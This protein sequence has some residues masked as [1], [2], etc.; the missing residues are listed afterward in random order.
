MISSIA[1]LVALT[2]PPAHTPDK[3]NQDA[4]LTAPV[5]P[6]FPESAR[7]AGLGKST[8]LVKVYLSAKGTIASLGVM[9]SSGNLDLDQAALRAAAQSTYSPR[10]KNCKPASGLYVFK[11]MFAPNR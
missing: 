7:A 8:V 3:C 4:R 1:L 5:P 10:I 6:D 11:V 2:R 9:T